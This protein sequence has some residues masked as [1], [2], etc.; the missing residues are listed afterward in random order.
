[1]SFKV[2]G[3][4]KSQKERNETPPSHSLDTCAHLCGYGKSSLI[5]CCFHSV[6]G[7]K[8]ADIYIKHNR[9]RTILVYVIIVINLKGFLFQ[10]HQ[11][12]R[13]NKQ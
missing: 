11:D 8:R 13:T 9:L 7:V 4:R 12:Y 5:V 1:M 6:H 10:G 2:S 3:R